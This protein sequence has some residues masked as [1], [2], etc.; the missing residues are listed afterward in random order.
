MQAGERGK[1]QLMIWGCFGGQ[2]LGE[3]Q[4]L[5]LQI[6]ADAGGI[7]SIITNSSISWTS[8]LALLH[9]Q[10]ALVSILI[11]H[12]IIKTRGVILVFS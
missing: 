11:L 9:E 8:I 2:D 5:P 3:G 1:S 6:L 7:L 10:I 12:D 4:P